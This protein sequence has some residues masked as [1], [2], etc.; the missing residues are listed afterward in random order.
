MDE[1]LAEWDIDPT[2]ILAILTDNGSNMV[3]AF[4][5]KAA[6]GEEEEEDIEG[7]EEVFVDEDEMRF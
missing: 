2:K 5:A 1:I 6:K 7:E 3:A 4:R